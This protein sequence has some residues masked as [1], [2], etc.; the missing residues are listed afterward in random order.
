MG[1]KPLPMKESGETMRTRGNPLSTHTLAASADFPVA[2]AP[3]SITESSG[4]LDDSFTCFTMRRRE[5]SK[6]SNAGP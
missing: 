2:L 1:L 4:V 5:V 6:S 3:S